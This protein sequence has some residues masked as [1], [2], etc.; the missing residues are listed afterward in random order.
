MHYLFYSYIYKQQKSFRYEVN[1]LFIVPYIYELSVSTLQ[2]ILKDFAGQ[3]QICWV[4]EN[5]GAPNWVA[6]GIY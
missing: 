3:Y 5:A 2:Y 1:D 4:S 6:H